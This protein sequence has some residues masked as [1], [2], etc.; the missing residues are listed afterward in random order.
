MRVSRMF[1]FESHSSEEHS[2]VNI[3]VWSIVRS[4]LLRRGSAAG[5]YSSEVE[6]H[7]SRIHTICFV[8]KPFRVRGSARQCVA[9]EEPSSI[10]PRDTSADQLRPPRPERPAT[11]THLLGTLC[12]KLS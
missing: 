7:S 5:D 11:V 6:F 3:P 2:G 1:G 10:S 9:P 4:R 12:K 8:R